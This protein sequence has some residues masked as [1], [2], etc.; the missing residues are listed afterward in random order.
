MTEQVFYGPYKI[1]YNNYRFTSENRSYE[2]W[3]F[4]NPVAVNT[5]TQIMTFS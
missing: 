5:L 3:V 4:V 1:D 2:D